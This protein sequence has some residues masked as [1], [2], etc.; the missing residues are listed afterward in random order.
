MPVIDADA[1][2]IETAATFADPYWDSRLADR[3]PR[4]LDLGARFAWLIDDV[5]YPKTRGK[6]AAR[7]GGPAAHDG[8]PSAFEAGKPDPI[9]SITLS[10]PEARCRQMDAEGIDVQVIFPSMFLRGQLAEDSAVQTALC[11]SYNA[12]IA[13]VC[14]RRA[15]RL[16]WVAVVNLRDIPGAITELRRCRERAAAGVMILGGAGDRHLNH[17]DVA[18]FFAAAEE[19][20]LPVA[21]H[22]G[23]PRNELADL[24]DTPFEQ[25]VLPFTVSMFM[26]FVDV[27]AGGLLDRF[28]R[29][30]MAFLEAGSQWLPFLV[31][32]MDHYAQMA[33]QRRFT[34]YRAKDLPS[35]YLRRG[36]IFVSCEVDDRLLPQVIEQFGEDVLI[37]ASDIPHGDREYDAVSDLRKRGDI[38]DRAKDKILGANARRFYGARLD[39]MTGGHR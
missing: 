34:D 8:R 23:R 32:R 12:W 31:D 11:R 10:D 9:E 3:R 18:P 16:T 25:I 21:V 37:F 7:V 19:L 28:E 5:V 17:P 26:G 30:R 27:I 35:S 13:D 29:L 24:F 14:G 6:G 38:S 22:A 4:V 1:H 36:N 15:D 39:R 20:D 2:V 33:L